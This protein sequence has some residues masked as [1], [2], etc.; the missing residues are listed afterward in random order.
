MDH[1]ESAQCLFSMNT[2]SL[3]VHLDHQWLG[4]KSFFAWYNLVFH[5]AYVTRRRHFALLPQP[6]LA[7]Q[8]ELAHASLIRGQT[9]VSS[10]R[11]VHATSFF[12]PQL[13]DDVYGAL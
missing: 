7:L 4:R 13:E 5:L 1:N 11:S 6:G 12:G 8:S 9:L 3:V 10:Q 2:G